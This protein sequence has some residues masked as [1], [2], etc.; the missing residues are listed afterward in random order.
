[1]FKSK[2]SAYVRCHQCCRLSQKEDNFFYDSFHMV[3]F[4]LWPPSNK[5]RQLRHRLHQ[6]SGNQIS[7][8]YLQGKQIT[9]VIES[10]KN[11]VKVISAKLKLHNCSKILKEVMISRVK[12]QISSWVPDGGLKIISVLTFTLVQ[13]ILI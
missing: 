6:N 5:S 2:R 11:I 1:M 13:S 4:V 9:F 12:P 3:F 7:V 8:V 10:L